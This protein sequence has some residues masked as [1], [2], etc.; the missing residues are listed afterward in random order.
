MVT[1]ESNAAHSAFWNHRSQTAS[2]S[3]SVKRATR[4]GD[5]ENHA[6]TLEVFVDLRGGFIG[7]DGHKGMAM[8]VDMN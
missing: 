5:L 3:K 1:C 6:K 8:K 2:L 4:Q 7:G